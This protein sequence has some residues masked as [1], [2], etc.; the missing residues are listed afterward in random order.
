[1]AG[2][3]LQRFTLPL[4]M[5][6]EQKRGIL[7]Y[8]EKLNE[9]QF[10]DS[11]HLRELQVSK[12]KQLLIHAFENTEYYRQIFR[13][14]SF[15]PYQ[16]ADFGEL[17]RIPILTKNDIAE[18]RD[19]LVATSFERSEL[20]S[21]FTGGTTGRRME[22]VRNNDCLAEKEAALL[23]FE[24]WAGW[25]IGKPMG[26][27]WPAQQDY[28]GYFTRKARI[29]NFLTFR[30]EVF[31]AAVAT[32]ESVLAYLNLIKRKNIKFIRSFA[33]PIYFLAQVATANNFTFETPFRGIVSTGEPL[34]KWQRT[35]IEQVFGCKVFDSY[36]SREAGPVSQECEEHNGQHVA[37]E[38]IYTESQASEDGLGLNE[39]LV[40]DLLNFGMPLIRY[41][42]GDFGDLVHEECK[43]GRC[44]PRINNL[45]GRVFDSFVGPNG[46]T[47]SSS[48]LVLY[49]VDEAPEDVGQIQVV[50]ETLQDVTIRFT[51]DLPLS[52]D[53]K[54]Y[55]ERK[56]KEIFGEKLKVVFQP[57]G[58]IP[59][60][61]SGKYRF[62]ICNARPD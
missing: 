41:R 6:R 27:V 21:S 49:L 28:V 10:L 18:N 5:K 53:V 57:V 50:Q 29:R 55:Q 12:L 35:A 54:N 1:M 14:I 8:L 46:Q 17:E 16:F 4:I 36:R 56:L 62:S 52:R 23:R 39:L 42:T 48:S 38:T 43:C 40:T 47:I 2:L 33:G 13:D 45:N 26:L 61:K 37:F 51:D 22:F 44:G 11:D 3:N 24:E 19:A 58:E 15:D 7:K 31:P 59:R 25:E 20:H 32:E 34:F 9:S 30:H 60:E